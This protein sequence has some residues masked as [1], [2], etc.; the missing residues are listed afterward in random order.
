MAIPTEEV[1]LCLHQLQGGDELAA[2]RL[3]PHV[4]NDLRRVAGG[5][6]KD[7]W[8]AHTLQPTALVHEAYLRLVRP[9][10]QGF[11]S[12]RHFMRA[13]ALAM[14]QLLTDYARARAT[15][16]R[17]GGDNRVALEAAEVEQVADD[18]LAPEVDLVALDEALTKLRELEPR[19]ADI[20]E[21]R[22]LGGLTVAE[23]AEALDVKERTV[24]LD[25]SMARVWLK[26]ELGEPAA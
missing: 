9:Q 2:E 4:Y 20:V 8:R 3:L 15:A 7:Q 5:L 18:A 16:K 17:G 26:R 23:V 14:R 24:Y 6:F 21:L 12:R 13:A 1:T 22:Y 25:W 10:D 19:Q 11:E